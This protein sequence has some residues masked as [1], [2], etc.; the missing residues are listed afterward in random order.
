MQVQIMRN[1]S[2]DKCRES[3]GSLSQ[4]MAR[5]RDHRVKPCKKSFWTT[6]EYLCFHLTEDH[7]Y[8]LNFSNNLKQRQTYELFDINP[9]PWILSIK[10]MI[11]SEDTDVFA[12]C[13]KFSNDTSW[14]E[15]QIVVTDKYRIQRHWYGSILTWDDVTEH[16]SAQL[17]HSTLLALLQVRES[18]RP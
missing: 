16:W 12:L 6:D 17:C 1:K 2:R 5:T 15:Y 4:R 3:Q 8:K 11:A 18:C 10:V 14:W 9:L 7:W 13:L